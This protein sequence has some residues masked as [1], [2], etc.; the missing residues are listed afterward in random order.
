MRTAGARGLVLLVLLVVALSPTPCLAQ[1]DFVSK[2]F[3]K[4]TNLN[5]DFL[6]G[7]PIGDRGLVTGSSGG[8]FL[9]RLK[10]EGIEATIDL[11]AIAKRDSIAK[12]CKK[13]DTLKRNCKVG[14]VLNGP[15]NKPLQQSCEGG[16]TLKLKEIRISTT[17]PVDTVAVDTVASKKVPPG[18][19]VLVA[20]LGFGYTQ[21]GGFL[22]DSSLRGSLEELP[23]LSIYLEVFPSSSWVS[24]YMGLRGG[25]TKL[26]D[27]RATVNN[28]PLQ[29]AGST[30]QYGLVAGLSFG[31]PQHGWA[32]FI[33]EAWSWRRFDGVAWTGA[34]AVPSALQA[35]LR[36]YTRTTSLGGQIFVGIKGT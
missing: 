33:E 14:D 22:G 30:F 36:L 24:P 29:G 15:D 34:P 6:F 31:K 32:L 19:D 8:G 9:G 21:L 4:V 13:S 25:L 20:E 12:R 7:T 16:D 5:A 17:K 18:C 1:L 23:A 27:L 2:V 11:G 26:K 3:S 35:P 28:T 10:G